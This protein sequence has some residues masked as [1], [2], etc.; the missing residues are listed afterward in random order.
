MQERKGLLSAIFISILFLEA[1]A[2][3]VDESELDDYIREDEVQVGTE[4]LLPV[5]KC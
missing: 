1:P 4:P 5:N 2:T 3:T